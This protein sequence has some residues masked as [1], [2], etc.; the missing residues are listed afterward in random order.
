MSVGPG[1]SACLQCLDKGSV[2]EHVVEMLSLFRCVVCCFAAFL[3]FEER[4]CQ[5]Q[6]V[7]H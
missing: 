1:V 4:V 7:L 6:L 2:H 5:Y 3:L